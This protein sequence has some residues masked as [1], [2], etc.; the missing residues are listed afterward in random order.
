[1]TL[2]RSLD[3]LSLRLWDETTGKLVGFKGVL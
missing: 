1:M 3:T 2:R